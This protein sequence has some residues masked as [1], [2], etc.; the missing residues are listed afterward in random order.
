MRTKRV[1]HL[2]FYIVGMFGILAL[3]GFGCAPTVPNHQQ[4]DASQEHADTEETWVVFSSTRTG[5]GDVYGLNLNTQEVVRIMGS[6][7]SEGGV[8]YDAARDRIV[9]QRH[10]A[11]S[12]ETVLVS[13]EDELFLDP[14]GDV[15]PAWSP[16]G[17]RIV[18]V[19]ER[20]GQ[21]DL[22]LAKA[23]GTGEERLTNDAE[24]DRYPTWSPDGNRVAWARRLEAGWA[25]H[26]IDIEGGAASIEV[27]TQPK[28]YIGHPAW[29]PQGNAIAFD[30]LVDGQADIFSVDLAS[31]AV[32]QLTTR[33]GNDLIPAWSPDGQHVAF[34]GVLPETGNWEIWIVDVALGTLT[35]LTDHEAFD[36]G[37]VFVPASALPE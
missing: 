27:V 37:P 8:R 31:R 14:N 35:Q 28:G 22:Y 4:P 34:G 17:T 11:D 13:A 3:Y 20:N 19:A 36:G 26:T 16:D 12:G 24:V 7:A 29:S 5:E 10:N 32:T 25:I 6:D 18:Y 21:Q 2:P 15:A 9:Y 23:D 33:P 30:A 1:R